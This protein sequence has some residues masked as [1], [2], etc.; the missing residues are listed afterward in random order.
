M[1][2]NKLGLNEK[3]VEALKQN[4]YLYP[5]EIQQKTIPLILDGKDIVGRSQTGSGKTFAFGL[6]IIHDTH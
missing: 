2:F 6:P 3:I 5:T 4:G 1:E